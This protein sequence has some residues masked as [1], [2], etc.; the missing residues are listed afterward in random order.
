MVVE[1][2]TPTSTAPGSSVSEIWEPAALGNRLIGA[3][4]AVSVAAAAVPVPDHTGSAT[5]HTASIVTAMRRTGDPGIG[6]RGAD[7]RRTDAPL[8][9]CPG[10]SAVCFRGLRRR[11]PVGEPLK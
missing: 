3:T 1:K 4:V 5:A 8:V 11:A 6:C 9:V 10:L 7:E 2:R